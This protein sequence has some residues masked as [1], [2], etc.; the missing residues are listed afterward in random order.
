MEAVNAVALS[1]KDI[2][3]V[4]W[5]DTR[6]VTIKGIGAYR[7][8]LDVVL[9]EIV[10]QHVDPK[11]LPTLSMPYWTLAVLTKRRPHK[12][13]ILLLRFIVYRWFNYP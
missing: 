6:S 11:Q 4:T 8:G 10:R 5:G 1:Q 12:A 3:E 7:F 13:V 2:I 9:I